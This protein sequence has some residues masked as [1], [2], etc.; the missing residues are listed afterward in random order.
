MSF[1]M[2]Q[3]REVPK[4]LIVAIAAIV[5]LARRDRVSRSRRSP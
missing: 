4:M 5:M 1:A 3:H 2:Q